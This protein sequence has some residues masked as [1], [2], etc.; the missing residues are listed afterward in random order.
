[1]KPGESKSEKYILRFIASD[2]DR[3]IELFAIG[4]SPINLSFRDTFCIQ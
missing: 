3:A 1:M 4:F 2:K